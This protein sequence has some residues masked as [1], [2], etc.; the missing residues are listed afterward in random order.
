MIIILLFRVDGFPLEFEWQQVFQVSSTLRNLADLKN[1]VVCIVF[2]RPLISKSLSYS[3]DPLVTVPRAPVTITITVTFTFH[4][5]STSLAVTYLS[6]LFL[7][8]IWLLFDWLLLSLLLLLLLFYSFDF[9]TPELANGLS[10]E[11]GWQQVT[12]SLQDFSLYSGR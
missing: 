2:T 10:L 6:F 9:F 12:S 5:F 3:T 1:A 4:S 7:V 8:I 11:F